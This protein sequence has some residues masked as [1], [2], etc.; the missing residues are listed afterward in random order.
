MAT[1][2]IT[3]TFDMSGGAFLSAGLVI[4]ASAT[5]FVLYSGGVANTYTGNFTYPAGVAGAPPQGT[6]T[7]LTTLT[8]A[9]PSDFSNA[10]P[11]LTITRLAADAST[12]FSFLRD[13]DEGSLWAY[14]LSGDDLI[15]AAPNGNNTVFGFAGNDSIIGG[16][17][18]D[19]IFGGAGNDTLV[20]S[21][22][23]D[24]LD[25]NT[26]TNTAQY[27]KFSGNPSLAK[28]YALTLNG[29]TMTIQDRAGRDGL[30]TLVNIQTVQFNDQALDTT[31]FTKTAALS[32]SQIT[33]L[34]QLYIASFNRAPDALGLD[35][36][37]SQLKDGMSLGAIA[38]SFF[39]QPEAAAAYPAG[40]STQTF[41]TQVYNNV[42]GRGP[43]PAGLDYWAGQLQS[44]SV[45]KNGFL[46]A[47]INGAQGTDLTYLANKQ[48]VGAYY[49]L[50]Q[51]LSDANWART[52]MAGVDGTA[53][54]VTAA[55]ALTDGFAATAATTAG[56]ELVVKILGIVA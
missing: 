37:G 52:V 1:L 55:N 40:Q 8:G 41:V 5:R 19:R 54:S 38:A 51:G 21:G 29:S 31:W 36:W 42:L 2:S 10:Q 50:T 47:I 16:L 48:A 32:S 20:G 49:A 22:G 44:G 11:G 23:N 28:E 13:N 34:V 56:T 30:D 15:F 26:G 17:G 7:S 14:F 53:A 39:V 27:I 46:L 12:V 3:Q 6:V 35:Y 33:S 43:D 4:E 18:N 45:G 24:L 25:G 9:F